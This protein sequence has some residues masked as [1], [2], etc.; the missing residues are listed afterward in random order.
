[1]APLPPTVGE[2]L[3]K[4]EMSVDVWGILNGADVDLLINGAP[5]QTLNNV[6][7]WGTSFALGTPL[8]SGQAVT[9]RQSLGGPPSSESPAVLVGDVDL[10]PTPARLAPSICRCSSCVYADGVAPGSTITVFQGGSQEGGG[11]TQIVQVIAGRDGTACFGTGGGFA[12]AK[13]IFA[14]ATTCGVSSAPSPTSA[15]VDIPGPLPATNIHSPIYSCQTAID[16]DG[17][18]QGASIEVFANHVS[19]G[20]FCNCWGAVHVN[21]PRALNLNEA[22]TSKQTMIN[23]ATLCNVD[24]IE[25][26]QAVNVIA[27]DSGIKPA[28]RE[29]VYDGDAV[30]RVTNQVSG[31]TLSVFVKQ[32]ATE[33]N[34][35]SA[36]SSEYEEV[37]L[38]NP[39][40]AGQIVRVEQSLCGHTES[41]DPITVQPRPSSIPVPTVRAPLYSCGV[42]VPVDGVLKGAQVR[43]FQNGFPVGFAWADA[44]TV[45]V[46]IGPALA[47]GKNITAS[48]RVGGIDGLPSAGVPVSSAAAVPVPVVLGP[49]IIGSR[50]VQVGGVLPGAY[51]QVFDGGVLDG[52]AD[53]VEGTV[54]VSLS[55]PISANSSLQAGQALCGDWSGLSGPGPTPI[56]D[57]SAPGS[58]TPSTPSDTP[59]TSFNVPA[60]ADAGPETVSMTGELTFPQAPGNPNQVD[61]SGAPYPLVVI[62][63]GNHSSASP[64]YQGYRYLADLLVSQGIVCFSANLNPL[65]GRNNEIDSRALVILQHIRILLQRSTTPGDLLFNMIDSNRVGLVGHS[66]GAEG[67]VGAAVDNLAQPPANQL[68]IKGIVPIAPTNFLNFANP[69]PPLFVIYGSF[70]A[71]VSGSN[72]G[73]N[74]FFIYDHSL[75]PKAMLFIHRARHNGFNEVWTRP[76]EDNETS[77]PGVLSPAEH[78]TIAKAYISA[79]FQ[80]LFF[81]RTGYEIYLQGPARPPGL[82]GYSLHNQYQVPN[83]SVVDNYGDADTQLAIAQKNPIKRETNT[84]NQAVTYSEPG[85]D[86]WYDADMM[87]VSHN[88]H[89]S[90]GGQ[91]TWKT[92]DT[93]ISNVDT[94]DYSGF[95]VL[96]IRLG[97]QYTGQNPLNPYGQP[98]DLLVKLKTTSGDATVRVGSLTDLP[99]PDERPDALTKAPLKTVR[100]PLAAFKAVNQ[101]VRLDQVIGV[102]LD[103]PLTA[104]GAISVDDIEF[105]A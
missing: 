22:I 63:H 31:G 35:G 60:S 67:V 4:C 70:D 76:S 39:L 61:P 10:P 88:P 90:R 83:R 96:S 71:D 87:T 42:L 92:A 53:A 75:T 7:S 58:F 48:Q 6:Q 79:F 43:V 98:Q 27:P 56:S 18:T 84:L 26:P 74:P 51:V 97:Q 78:Q 99:F 49:L 64:S 34:V 2:R 15:L 41:S 94:R 24:G 14:T 25:N 65:N 29:V 105:S 5:V 52:S 19:L 30:I 33:S 3:V 89:D 38:N 45:V 20:S 57:P 12:N 101:A 28:I 91:L 8:T 1:M 62:A 44:T 11:A 69:G 77:L 23:P 40:V 37:S 102:E 103:F 68:H 104:F 32:G 80:D 9:A 55:Q 46:R 50:I 21:L 100:L 85:M 13:P 82:G 54:A 93:Y 17:L 73:V 66:R 86:V 47:A 81:G 95:A 36:G 72:A 59:A 16:M